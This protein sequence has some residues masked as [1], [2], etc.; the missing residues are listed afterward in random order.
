[1][2]VMLVSQ[3]KEFK[4]TNHMRHVYYEVY[5]KHRITIISN[6]TISSSIINILE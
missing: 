6:I 3:Y 5:K 1:M 4:F 2:S